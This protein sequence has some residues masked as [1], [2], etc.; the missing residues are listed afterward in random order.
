MIVV[1]PTIERIEG[2]HNSSAVRRMLTREALDSLLDYL[3]PDRRAAGERYEEIRGRLVRLF[4]WRGCDQAEELA[5]ETINRVADKIASGLEIRS[6]DPFRYFCGVGHLVFK[7]ILRRQQRER[8]ALEEVRHLPPPP[9]P[10]EEDERLAWLRD[11][12]EALE[13]DQRSL[14]LD[15]HRGEGGE[16]IRRRRAIAERLG[17]PINA[18]RIRVHR[19]RA[20]LEECVQH[21]ESENGQ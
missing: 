1:V 13:T 18:L 12:M 21:A 11:C 17:V 19:I 14:I 8:A 5:D 16:R 20:R 3:G 15:Y 9:E 4:Q 6:E 7:E 10:D 2:A